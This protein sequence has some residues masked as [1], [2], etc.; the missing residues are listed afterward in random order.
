VTGLDPE[1]YPRGDLFAARLLD[2]VYA[3]DLKQMDAVLLAVEIRSR[4]DPL[5]FDTGK[6]ELAIAT[7]AWAHREQRRLVR[8]DLPRTTYIEHPLRNAAR[9]LRWGVV[10]E[11]IV[12]ACILHD[13]VE[14]AP[15][16]LAE[17]FAGEAGGDE[18]VARE[19]V[20]RQF[21]TDFGERVAELV[22]ALSNPIRT[23]TLGEEDAHRAYREHVVD[24]TADPEVAVCKLADLVDN[25]L[26]LHHT[27][28]P[29]DPRTARLAR[30]YAPVLKVLRERVAAQDVR[31]LMSAD[32][33][34]AVTEAL[35]AGVHGGVSSVARRTG[36]ER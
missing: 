21:A 14:D 27:G 7:A 35:A 16:E 5:G 32:G 33:H 11:P 4:A 9:V 1:A 12:L 34:R 19:L 24:V 3:L 18:G 25:A 23:E 30:K 15:F 13:T 10:S 17:L 31:D 22:R 26:S 2:R 29:N 28:S 20:L 8:G 6:A 36:G